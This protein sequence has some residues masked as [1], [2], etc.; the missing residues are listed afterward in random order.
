MF[1]MIGNLQNQPYMEK[2]MRNQYRFLGLKTPDRKAQSK[3]IVT[4]SKKW[5]IARVFSTITALYQRDEREY[6]YVAIDIAYVNVKR[7]TFSDI[8]RLTAYIQIKSW[9]DTVDSWRKTFGQFV[10]LYPEEKRRVFNLFYQHENF[11]MRRIAITLQLLE[12]ETLDKELLTKAIEYD[13]NTEEFFIQKA[14]G[15]SLRNYSKYNPEWVK[16]FIAA[17]ELSKLA[18]KEGSKYL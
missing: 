2:Y 16:T 7:L 3:E 11:W 4:A 1:Q 8:D 15:W 6:Q 10:R 13:I 14:I 17:H 18:V 9:W 5:P 12:K